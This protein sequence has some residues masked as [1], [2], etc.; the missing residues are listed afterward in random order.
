[1]VQV[2]SRVLGWA[3]LALGLVSIAVPRR[4][5]ESIGVRP[6]AASVAISRLVGLREL[7]VVPGLLAVKRPVGWLAA[8]VAG[9]AMDVALLL[10]AHRSPGNDRGRVRGA[11][12]GVAAIM[13]TDIATA[14]A[15]RR[16]AK[17]RARHP[18]RIVQAVTVNRPV[19]ELYG[20]WRQL[21]NLP[22]VMP[23]LESVEARGGSTSHWVAKGPL[24]ARVE[25]DAEIVDDRPNELV[26]WRSV[27]GAD[28]RNA[29]TV[30]FEPATGGRGTVVSV[31]M[32]YDTPGG[33]IGSVAALLTGEEPRIQVSDALRRFKQVMET[34]EP[35]R[36]A[37]TA[38]GHKIAQRPA[39]PP[40]EG[41]SEQLAF[42]ASAE[43]NP[44]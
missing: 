25:W 20:F 18:G 37:A 1:M 10:W 34:G 42:A 9:D 24:G 30:R 15:A 17:E 35:I 12:G 32:E 38:T 19:D 5:L 2:V 22:R 21:E 3:S 6:G 26:A 33:A 7:T 44:S 13:A 14:I 27:E 39:Q 29:G 16:E 40:D 31:E 23:H 36:S 41:Q 28:V 8:R 43:G 11:L 4:F